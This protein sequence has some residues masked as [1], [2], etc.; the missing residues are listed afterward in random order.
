[1]PSL[2]FIKMQGLGN[3]FVVFDARKKL[4]KL[5]AAQ[6]R[7][8]ADRRRGIGCDQ[9]IVIEAASGQRLAT[10][11]KSSLAASRQPLP[12]V[13]M[14]IYNADGGEVAACGN[15]TRCIA[16]LIMEETGKKKV[17]IETKA[18]IIACER[19]GKN[20]VRAD[21]GKP[22]FDWKKIPLARECDTEALPILMNGLRPSAVNM[23]NPHMVFAVP[24]ADQIPLEKIGSKLERH[25]LYPKRANV[26]FAEVITKSRIKLRVWERGAGA[27]LACGTAACAAVVALHRRELI[28]S[29]ADVLLPGGTLEIEWD[30]KYG[31]VFMTGPA[32]LAF[33]G[34]WHG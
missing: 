16:W 2:P 34:E 24:H 17:V 22:Q 13:F 26:S 9:V 3:D 4:L 33:R 32:A 6:A 14:R 5:S 15:A 7:A 30:K 25:P 11:N 31:H 1:M 19:V 27:T 28:S 18:G 10:R 21:M 8:L 23:G 29:K 12:T 20:K